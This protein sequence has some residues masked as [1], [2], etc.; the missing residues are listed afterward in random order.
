[1]QQKYL[2]Y[3]LIDWLIEPTVA[4]FL[5]D[6]NNIGRM[7]RVDTESLHLRLYGLSGPQVAFSQRMVGD[8]PRCMKLQRFSPLL[9]PY[10]T[11]IASSTELIAIGYV[12][13]G[14]KG[15]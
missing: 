13:Q 3:R 11:P 7:A 10:W 5:L 12:K 15:L 4:N 1:V 2:I 14:R 9:R 8:S 6:C